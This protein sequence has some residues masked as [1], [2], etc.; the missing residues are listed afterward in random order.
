MFGVIHSCRRN[1]AVEVVR[2]RAADNEVARDRAAHVAVGVGVISIVVR[3]RASARVDR[4][5]RVVAVA[6]A[7]VEVELAARV[8]DVLRPDRARVRAPWSIEDIPPSGKVA[9]SK[10]RHAVQPSIRLPFVQ[11][12]WDMSYASDA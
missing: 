2:G 10:S 3:V 8:N 7:E 11:R 6:K 12:V 1:V 9:F 5:V 4:E